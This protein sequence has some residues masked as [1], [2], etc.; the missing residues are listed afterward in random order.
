MLRVIFMCV[1]V[2]WTCD[3]THHQQNY[4]RMDFTLQVFMDQH[5]MHNIHSQNWETNDIILE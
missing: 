2:F 5:F 1:K 4:I 3:C